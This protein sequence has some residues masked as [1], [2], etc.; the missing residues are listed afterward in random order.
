MN[1]KAFLTIFFIIFLSV[2]GT[3]NYFVLYQFT[4]M[5]HLERNLAF[6]IIFIFLTISYLLANFLASSI[7][8][9]VTKAIYY[10]ASTWMGMLFLSFCFLIIYYILSYFM[11]LP[12]ILSGVIIICIVLILTIYSIHNA[13]N[14]RTTTINLKSSKL[15]KPL[16]I[17][18][19]SDVHL[20]PV[21]GKHCLKGL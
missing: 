19:L 17:V 16:R 10:F 15:E 6:Y 8:A 21:N 7:N 1:D 11:I 5:F 13:D 12:S 3:L 20:G 18:Q 2:Y 4:K 9:A 14:I